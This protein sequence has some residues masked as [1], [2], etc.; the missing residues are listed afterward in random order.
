MRVQA[1][2]VALLA[3]VAASAPAGAQAGAYYEVSGVE[4]YYATG[5]Y[6][7]GHFTVG[8]D[9]DTQVE[10]PFDGCAWAKLRPDNNHG[11]IQAL[12]SWGSVPLIID[13]N[14]FAD[15]DQTP[16]SMA[17]DGKASMDAAGSGLVPASMTA[18]ANATVRLGDESI[19]DPVTGSPIFQ[20]EWFV[21]PRGF[22]DDAT[23]AFQ[24]EGPDSWEMHLRVGSHPDEGTQGPTSWT[25]A[26][27]S[28]GTILLAP[29]EAHSRVYAIP[30]ERLFGTGTLSVAS[31]SWAPAGSTDLAFTVY[32]P[33]GQP[34]GTFSVAPALNSPATQS[35]EFPLDQYGDYYV[36]VHGAVN[37]AS[38]EVTLEQAAPEAFVLD[39]WWD[40]ITPG[41]SGLEARESCKDELDGMVMTSLIASLPPPTPF[42]WEFSLFTVAAGLT[43]LIVFVAFIIA[44][45]QTL[46]ARRAVQG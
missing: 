13:I 12:G 40:A 29:D 9:A 33:D 10:Q 39:L 5:T 1:L 18:T 20:A 32:A 25:Q 37:L 43:V 19:L 23:G 11:R 26:E 6:G 3:L 42:D 34:K 38:Y 46:A 27:P 36:E 35:L 21:T 45:Y 2:A 44:M 22:R 31:N 15:A 16:D 7:S 41:Y 14:N 30:N 4:Y 17:P 24:P 8:P 28:D